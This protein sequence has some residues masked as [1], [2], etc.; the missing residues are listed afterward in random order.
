MEQEETYVVTQSDLENLI[1]YSRNSAHPDDALDETGTED[2]CFKL[3]DLFMDITGK[4]LPS[5]FY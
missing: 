4:N 2:A 5:K 1:M 3:D